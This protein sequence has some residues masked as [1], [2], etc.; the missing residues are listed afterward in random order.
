MS[1]NSFS[2]L[3]QSDDSSLTSSFKFQNEAMENAMKRAKEA[4]E[5]K[6]AEQ[7]GAL[8]SQIDTLNNQKLQE[9]RNIRK[10]ERR[11]KENL[12]NFKKAVEYFMKSGNFG[13]LYPFM[14]YPIQMLCTNLGVS[15]PTPEE[16]KLPE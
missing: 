4:K 15:L 13:P 6:L 2:S 10:Q 16:Q 7:A 3:F 1:K 11:A 8:F 9:L 5:T 12:E 14:P